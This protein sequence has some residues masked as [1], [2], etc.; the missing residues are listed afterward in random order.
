MLSD[1]QQNKKKEMKLT[2]VHFLSLGINAASTLVSSVD[3]LYLSILPDLQIPTF[4][5]SC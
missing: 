3:E 4:P 5:R 2:S 1:T